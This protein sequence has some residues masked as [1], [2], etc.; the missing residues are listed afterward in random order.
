MVTKTDTVVSIDGTKFVVNG[1]PTHKGKTWRGHSLEGLLFN[2]R[3]AQA[4]TDDENPSTRGVWMYPD[5]EVFTAKRNNDEFVAALKDYRAHGLDAVCINLQSGSPQGYSNVQ[6]WTITGFNADGS[7]KQPW[8]DRLDRVITEADRLGMVV[9]LGLFYWKQTRVFADEAAVRRAVENTVDWLAERGARNVLL[10]IGN[11]VDLTFFQPI[12]EAPRCH[13]LIR[14]A[15]Q[16]SEGRFDTPGGRLLVSTSLA[17]PSPVGA[18]IMET[19]DFLLLHGNGTHHPDSVRLMA[20]ANRAQPAYRAMPVM[21]NE[22]DHFDFDKPDNNFAAAIG[23]Y[24]SWGYFDYRMNR[25][26]FEDGFQSLP[27]DWTINSDRKRAFFS[28]LKGI[29]GGAA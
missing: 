19:A 2:S 28:Y 9:V 21:I 23:E 1:E 16:R 18:N 24:L 13:E 4:L 7:I 8:L 22:D 14:L 12:I 15:Q 20:R 27:V 25:E 5:G 6:P 17:R 29:T 26:R 10:E 11:E 3:M